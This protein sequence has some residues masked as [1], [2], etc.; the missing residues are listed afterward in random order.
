MSQDISTVSGGMAYMV[1]PIFP[2]GVLASAY[3]QVVNATA[4]GKAPK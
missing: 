2:A 1:A 4:V 3:A